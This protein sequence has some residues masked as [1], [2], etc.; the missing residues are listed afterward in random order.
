MKVYTLR[1]SKEN[2]LSRLSFLPFFSFSVTAVKDWE[3]GGG[4][5]ELRW[6]SE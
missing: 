3:I 1:L 6:S 5:G 2:F 4:D